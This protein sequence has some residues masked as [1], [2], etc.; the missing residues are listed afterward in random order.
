MNLTENYQAIETKLRGFVD[1]MNGVFGF[2][3][4]QNMMNEKTDTSKTLGGDS[5]LRSLENRMRQLLQGSVYD[6]KGGITRLSELG[7]EFNRSGTLDFKED[8]FQKVLKSNPK[9]VLAFLKGDGGLQSGFI[10]KVRMSMDSALNHNYGIVSNKKKGLQNQISQIDRNIDTKEKESGDQR[11][12]LTQKIFENGRTDGQ[13][14]ST[15]RADWSH[16]RR[17]VAQLMGG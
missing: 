12:K 5:S 6:A 8:K 3:Q 11:K 4:A 14:P 17:Q 10:G 7:V 2:I 9:D 16:G 1:A 15:K 13:A